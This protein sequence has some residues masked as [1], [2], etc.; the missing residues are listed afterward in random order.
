MIEYSF[1][2][3]IYT[4]RE[5]SVQ[6]IMTNAKGQA[7]LTA[8]YSADNSTLHDAAWAWERNLNMVRASN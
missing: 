2:I 1:V 3:Y 4:Q 6:G 7:W 5:R 8:K